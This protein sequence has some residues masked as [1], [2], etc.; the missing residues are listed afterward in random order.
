MKFKYIRHTSKVFMH[1]SHLK[2][3]NRSFFFFC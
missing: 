1:I 3:H 2:V